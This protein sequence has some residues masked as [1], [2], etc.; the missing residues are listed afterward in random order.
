MVHYDF[1][2]LPELAWA[3]TVAVAAYLAMTIGTVNAEDWGKWDRLWVS[4]GVGAVR[5][6][7]GALVS[8]AGHRRRHEGTDIPPGG[9][10]MPET[11]AHDP[12]KK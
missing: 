5:A 6:A 2:W 3:V 1:K 7:L 9:P 12:P 8:Y 10:V 11:L 4:L